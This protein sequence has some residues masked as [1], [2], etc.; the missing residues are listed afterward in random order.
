[1]G[2]RTQRRKMLGRV[3]SSLARPILCASRPSFTTTTTTFAPV[4]QRSFFSIATLPFSTFVNSSNSPAPI[5][6]IPNTNTAVRGFHSLLVPV[7]A[8][9]GIP[10]FHSSI[11]SI[12][13][14]GRGKKPDRKLKSHSGARKR[15][16]LTGSGAFKRMRAGRRHLAQSKDSRRMRH[17]RTPAIV[18]KTNLRSIRSLI[19]RGSSK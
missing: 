4:I 13:V 5:P 19:P 3:V 11:A 8:A 18:H 9:S 6:N 14:R 10:P 7:F 15:F 16:R 12:Q 17:L 1:M 2:T